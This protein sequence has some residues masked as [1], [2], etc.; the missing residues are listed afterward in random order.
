MAQH[1]K[2]NHTAVKPCNQGQLLINLPVIGGI[3]AQILLP[4]NHSHIQNLLSA[5]RGS[6]PNLIPHL[7]CRLFDPGPQLLT[8]PL[9]SCQCIGYCHRAHLQSLCDIRQTHC[10]LHLNLPLDFNLFLTLLY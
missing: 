10:F 6:P 7:C 5:T 9:L 1:L 4:N 8:D 3:S 2:K